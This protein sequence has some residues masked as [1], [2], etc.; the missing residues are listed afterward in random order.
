MTDNPHRPPW[1]TR[2]AAA[3][4]VLLIAGGVT[5]VVLTRDSEPKPKRELSDTMTS[6]LGEAANAPGNALGDNVKAVM[7]CV[8]TATAM[9]DSAC[10]D[11]KLDDITTAREAEQDATREVLAG[12]SAGECRSAWQLAD[13]RLTRVGAREGALRKAI[14]A[15]FASGTGNELAISD[16]NDAM[17]DGAIALTQS[18]TDAVN[19]HNEAV[20]A[21]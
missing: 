15:E 21:C 3:A 20:D 16:A 5:A 4:V 12:L 11:V 9:I 2:I 1:P 19:A 10:L 17:L 7:D 13:R 6:S 18:A 14:D 8:D